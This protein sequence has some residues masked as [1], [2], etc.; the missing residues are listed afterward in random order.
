MHKS[1]DVHARQFAKDLRRTFSLLNKESIVSG[2]NAYMIVREEHLPICAACMIV[3][4]RTSERRSSGLG[5]VTGGSWG[6]SRLAAEFQELPELLELC[7]K[8]LDRRG[9]DAG[10]DR[11]HLLEISSSE[12]WAVQA[13]C[14]A[15]FRVLLIDHL[16]SRSRVCIASAPQIALLGCNVQLRANSSPSCSSDGG[17]TQ[18]ASWQIVL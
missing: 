12:P 1:I 11:T 14:T 7:C 9:R 10:A 13:L 4:A 17:R 8:T 18:Q 15:T 16:C 3:E 5:T 6:V 2:N